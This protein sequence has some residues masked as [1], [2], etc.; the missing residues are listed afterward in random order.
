MLQ[1]GDS[2]TSSLRQV[3]DWTAS[4]GLLS[5]PISRALPAGKGRGAAAARAE[6]ERGGRRAAWDTQSQAAGARELRR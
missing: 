6:E 3:E 5:M 4:D 2:A 1:P